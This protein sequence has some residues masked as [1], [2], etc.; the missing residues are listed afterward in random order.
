M[1]ELCRGNSDVGEIGWGWLGGVAAMVRGDLGLARGGGG[2]ARRRSVVGDEQRQR[3]RQ[4]RASSEQRSKRGGGGKNQPG[5][6]N[7]TA[8]RQKV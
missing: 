3:Q 5:R 1:P 4:S 8:T 2:F 6:G 7:C